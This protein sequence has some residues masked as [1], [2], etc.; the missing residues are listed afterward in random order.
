MNYCQHW[1]M[2][3]TARRDYCPDCGYEFYY[4]D[5]HSTGSAQQSRL[6][7]NDPNLVGCIYAILAQGDDGYEGIMAAELEIDGRRMLTPL[8]GADR[9]R[10]KQLLPIANQISIKSG[11]PY[12][13]YCFGNKVDIT[14]EI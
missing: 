14:E 9:A 11:R 3:Q 8:I 5:A 1:G 13:V 4:G 7:N 12:R 6:V 2:I 10:I